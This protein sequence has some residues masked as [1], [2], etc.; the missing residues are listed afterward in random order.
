MNFGG[1]EGVGKGAGEGGGGIC[2]PESNVFLILLAPCP[3]ICQVP[4]TCWGVWG[5]KE[6]EEGNSTQ[7]LP[8]TK[9]LQGFD[10]AE[11][12]VA[13]G[14]ITTHPTG[15]GSGPAVESDLSSFDADKKKSHQRLG[16]AG[17]RGASADG[18][19]VPTPRRQ[20]QVE[21]NSPGKSKRAGDNTLLQS[22]GVR[23]FLGGWFF[24]LIKES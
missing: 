21:P 7:R 23:F 17:R 6:A 13:T 18:P 10:G 19:L 4:F 12:A 5:L 11:E 8:I 2:G 9:L 14:G 3:Q 1:E 24:F 22:P 16:G 15:T 20:S